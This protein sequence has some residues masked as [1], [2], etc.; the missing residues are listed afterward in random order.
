MCMYSTGQS[1]DDGK[2]TSFGTGLKGLY[3][4]VFNIFGFENYIS[5]LIRP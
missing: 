4:K 1:A 2:R 3:H 5:T